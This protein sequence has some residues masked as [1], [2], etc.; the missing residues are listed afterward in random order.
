[1]HAY[2]L[3][4]SFAA[5]LSVALFVS[6]ARAELV[7]VPND[8]KVVLV[9]GAQ[10]VVK[11]PPPDT[12]AVIDLSGERPRLVAEIDG[13]PNSVIGPPA[14]A[15]ITPNEE[16]ALVASSNHVDPRDPTKQTGDNRLT[17]VDLTTRP[18]RVLATLETGG[19]PSGVGI[20]RAG[21]LALVGNHDDGTVSVFAIAGKNVTPVGR[22]KVAEAATGVRQPVFAPDGR[23]AILTCDS[24]HEVMLL[25]IDGQKVSPA[26]RSIRPGL[27]PY[28]G[29]VSRDGSIA[30]VGNVGF[31]N[32]DVD[33]LGVI[34]LRAEPPRLVDSLNVGLTP[35]CVVLSPD[36]SLC[37]VILLNGSTKPKGTPFFQPQGRLRLYRVSGTKLTFAAEAPI[38]A[39]PQGVTI[40]ADNRTVL[41]TSMVE[42]AVHVFR[43]DGKALS[44][45]EPLK[46]KGGPSTIGRARK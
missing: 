6:T 25:R 5:T 35:E 46:M 39:W 18:P 37:A 12:L 20:N 16:L 15:A 10:V 31:L 7:V 4:R 3:L 29:D 1:M 45:K 23:T 32:G 19:M 28:A 27:K 38:G 30:V 36:G 9:N 42:K 17:V 34:D 8:N 24:E 11:D 22:V 44:E 2:P 40:S 26:G 33:T 14:G 43:W 21:T 41:A 13:V